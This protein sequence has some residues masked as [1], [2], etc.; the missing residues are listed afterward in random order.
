MSYSINEIKNKVAKLPKVDLAFL[1]TPLYKLE[2]LSEIL[3]I[4][5][6]IKRD[7]FTGKNLFGGNKTR[8]L[9]FLIG[10]AL[11]EKC[12]HVFTFGATQ[13]NHAMQTAWAARLNNLNPILYLT[14]VVS[15]DEKD[16]K[17]NLLLDKVYDAE[18]HLVYPENGESF[19]DAEKR[20]VKM[21]ED[22]FKE[23]EESGQKSMII[24]M[25]GANE[26]G[27]VGYI[28]MM[29]ELFDQA[30][31][32]GLTFDKLYHA[33]GSGGTMAGIIAGKQ[34]LGWDLEV[35][36]M[37]ALDISSDYLERCINLTNRTLEYANFNEEVKPD[38]F[39][40]FKDS[41]L[42]G[43]E[44]PS[45]AGSKAIKLLARTEGLLL[46]PV[47]TGKAFGQMLKDIESGKISKGSN[48]IFLHTG[49][50]TGLFSEKE[51][52]GDIL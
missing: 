36:S 28:A 43:Y 39:N 49:G 3:D 29:V 26:V 9:E 27:S 1:P 11:K 5:L 45:E 30:K 22:H 25:G 6:F 17:A 7:D 13:S 52:I 14:A 46:D 37:A 33:T 20:S 51:I 2:K 50:A 34:L 47:Y 4:N 18:I 12:Y 32:I 23:L 44:I 41:F 16:L 40:I 31:S 21:A 24:P 42:P 38:Y 48:I 35:Q 8:K 15:P 19:A 10:K